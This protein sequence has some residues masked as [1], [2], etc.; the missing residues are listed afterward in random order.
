MNRR[1]RI[2]RCAREHLKMKSDLH[3]DSLSRHRPGV[4]WRSVLIVLLLLPLNMYWHVQMEALR[5]TFPSLMAPFYSVI[6]DLL[7]LT[8]LNVPLKKL[9]PRYALTPPELITIYVLLSAG[10]LFMSYDMFLPLVSIMAHAF[11]FRS[12]ANQWDTLFIPYLPEHLTVRDP[13]AVR[14]FYRGGAFSDHWHHWLIPS[15]W[16]C[17]FTL[18]LV[19]V[20]LSLNLL[21]RKQWIEHERLS[22]PIVYL[23]YEIAFNPGGLFRQRLF[24]CG[25]TIAA[26]IA[27]LNGLN[28]LDA[29]FP[30][31]PNKGVPLSPLL[32][33]SARPWNALAKEPW[34]IIVYPWAVGL[35]Y[36]MPLDVLVSCQIFFWL[37]K[38][39]F[40]LGALLGWDT[41]PNFPF[42]Y[43]QNTGAYT[44][45]AL[46][47][48][49]AARRHLKEAVATGLGLKV[50][51]SSL[52]PSP[53]RKRGIAGGSPQPSTLNPWEYRLALLG[54]L[55]GM[56][57]LLGF[58][59]YGGMS[60]WAAGLFFAAHLAIALTLTRIRAEV[61]FPIHSTT[62]IG[63][64]H[65]LVTLLGTRT[66]GVQNLTFFALFFWFNRDNRSH[67]MPHQA[68][69][70]FLAERSNPRS[71]PLDKEE[72]VEVHKLTWAILGISVIAMPL[73]LWILLETLYS[74]GVS[75]GHVGAQI[76][77][78]G[79]RAY[80]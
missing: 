52:F 14:D 51:G 8:V 10:V 65:S 22:Y 60:L 40:V 62:F 68:E 12:A 55:I 46:L 13:A 45:V 1:G 73:C 47:V 71:L 36:L 57:F 69:A 4:T 20:C 25:F 33:T 23:P 24:W 43:E 66:I 70:F 15:L 61:G 59:V 38:A 67:P 26:G 80:G 41:I 64:H 58:S 7:V 75:S 37:H 53:F 5:Y 19:V 31:L 11:W 79:G 76:N 29:R 48:L 28:L 21:L 77:S 6:F 78:F 56:A 72:K 49:W 17:G 42:K 34:S 54:I 39:Q 16:W 32:E 27:L 35:G 30:S 50:K 74:R 44:A 9:A 3:P 2:R 63:P 18:A